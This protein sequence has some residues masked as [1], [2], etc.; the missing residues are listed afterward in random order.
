ML[1]YAVEQTGE[2]PHLLRAFSRSKNDRR[3]PRERAF[4]Q[5]QGLGRYMEPADPALCAAKQQCIEH[6][7]RRRRGDRLTDRGCGNS[8]VILEQEYLHGQRSGSGFRARPEHFEAQRW[9][10]K[11]K[12]LPFGVWK[13]FNVLHDTQALG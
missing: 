4:E 8:S 11:N 10:S 5:Q 13:L 1:F 7:V 2:I 6:V 12:T 3:L 9:M